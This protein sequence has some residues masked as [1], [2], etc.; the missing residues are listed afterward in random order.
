MQGLLSEESAKLKSISEEEYLSPAL[1]RVSFINLTLTAADKTWR[2]K[3]YYKFMMIRH[4]LERLLSGYRDKIEPLLQMDYS[5][6]NNQSLLKDNIIPKNMKFFEAHRRWIFSK[7]RPLDLLKWMS[8]RGSYNIQLTF[9]D[10]VQWI[11][12]SEDNSLNEHFSSVLNNAHPCIIRYNFYANFKNYSREVRLL[13][14]R[15]DTNPNFF[16]DHNTHKAWDETKSVMKMYYSQLSSELKYR[17]FKRMY[18]E[19]D[20]YYHLY[21]EDQ[22]SH[23]E[24]LGVN[25]PILVKV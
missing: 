7:Y 6:T 23:V 5:V 3:Q 1:K 9:S 21:P 15:L 4:P 22:W 25:E 24:L 20:F 14:K 11:I 10:F 18:K 8:G 12:N 19:L 13:V 16:T 2:L 17:L